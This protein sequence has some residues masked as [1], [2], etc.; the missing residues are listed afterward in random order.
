MLGSSA[1][2]CRSSGLTAAGRTRWSR[3]PFRGAAA[4]ALTPALFTETSLEAEEITRDERGSKG[5][6][7]AACSPD[8][9]MQLMTTRPAHQC[10]S[11]A[12]AKRNVPGP[13]ETPTV[14]PESV[15]TARPDTLLRKACWSLLIFTKSVVVISIKVIT[16]ANMTTSS[17]D[18]AKSMCAR[19]LAMARP[20]GESLVNQTSS[21]SARCAWM[22]MTPKKM[23]VPVLKRVENECGSWLSSGSLR[24]KPKTE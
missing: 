22:V 12:L 10:S 17:A 15:S 6:L 16:S 5:T 14:R 4:E 13:R 24:M 20:L 7:V 18:Q 2:V 19:T 1:F 3:G 11:T 23:N 8:R 21:S 9:S